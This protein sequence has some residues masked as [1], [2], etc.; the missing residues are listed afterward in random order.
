MDKPRLTDKHEMFCQCIASRKMSA[1]DALREAYDTTNMKAETIHV[2]ACMM[3]KDPK[4][5]V[6][7][8]EIQEER[9][10]AI[11]DKYSKEDVIEDLLENKSRAKAVGKLDE[12][13]HNVKAIADITGMTQVEESEAP[14]TK[15]VVEFVDGKGDVKDVG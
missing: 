1:S 13:R 5:G 10:Q 14:V 12:V 9:Y 6:R 8:R 7:I 15:V 4:I 11:L 2:K 3:R